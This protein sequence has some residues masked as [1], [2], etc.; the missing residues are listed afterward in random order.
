MYSNAI[1]ASSTSTKISMRASRVFQRDV[2]DHIAGIAAAI[3]PFL[4]KF[5][6]VLPVNDDAG[7]GI[8]MVELTEQ[9]VHE[10]VG[11]SLNDLEALVTVLD[12][13]AVALHADLPDHVNYHRRSLLEHLDLLGDNGKIGGDGS[14]REALADLFDVLGDFVKCAR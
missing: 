4:E 13:F 11:L 7:V 10:F 5:E 12:S 6:K 1:A 9:F 14:D 8:A 3:D 2:K